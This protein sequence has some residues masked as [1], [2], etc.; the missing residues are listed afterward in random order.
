MA[1]IHIKQSKAAYFRKDTHFIWAELTSTFAQSSKLYLIC[2]VWESNAE[3]VFTFCNGRLLTRDM[4]GSNLEN[5]LMT[6]DL[7]IHHYNMHS[8]RLGAAT[9]AKQAALWDLH[10][11]T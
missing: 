1:C 9:S 5:V 4:F 8:F 2:A 10:I 7:Q 3:P 6:L 11:V